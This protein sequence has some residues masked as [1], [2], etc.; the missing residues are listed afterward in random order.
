[1]TAPLERIPQQRLD[2]LDRLCASGIDPYPPR[3]QRTHTS[4]GAK[5]LL[6]EQ[7]KTGGDQPAQ[8][9]LAGRITAQRSMG[10]ALFLDLQDGSGRI[11]LLLRNDLVGLE[12]Y[13]FAKVLDIGDILG[14][15]GRLIRTRTGEITLDVVDFSLL[16]KSLQPLP[17]KWHG[18]V[19][20]EKRYRQR[21]LDLISNAEVRDVFRKRSKVVSA[22]RSFFDSRGFLEVQTPVLQPR[23]GGATARPFITHHQALDQD[24]F[25]RIALELHLKRLIIGGFDKVYEIG[26][27]FRNEGISAR[28]NPEFTIMESY[29]AYADYNQVMSMVEELVAHV[30][31]HVVGGTRIEFNGQAI[32]L[33]PPW[34]RVSLREAVKEGAGLDFEDYHD[35]ASLR[36][37]MEQMGMTADPA[38]SRGKL[39]DDIL[40]AFVQPHLIQP[41]FLLDYPVEMSPL[42]KRKPDD[43]RFVERFEGFC[44][45]MEIANAFTELNNPLEQRER[46][47]EQQKE[48]EAGDEEVQLPDEDF[49]LALE[50]GMPPTGGLGMGVDRLVMLLTGQ[51]SIRDVI[52][53]PQL[54]TKE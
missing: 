44:G 8:V 18:L 27:A 11:Q 25:L 20:V 12:H 46:F 52:L 38:K 35:A 32:D 1:M 31:C 54:R 3:Y 30:A 6:A 7:E 10:K 23:A 33:E 49:L 14:A 21:Y 19:D 37:K 53:F 48:R 51:S 5:A 43:P 39:I 9:S 36:A 40:D 45:G 4:E 41:T 50:Y 28:H 47:T 24:L 29:E 17:E 15:R 26:P 22:M 2:K 13:E 34:R 42:A 16:A